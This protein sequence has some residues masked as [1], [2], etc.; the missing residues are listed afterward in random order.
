MIEI[1]AV[2]IE[3][4]INNFTLDKELKLLDYYG[5]GKHRDYHFKEDLHRSVLGEMMVRTLLCNKS[6]LK[7]S[8]LSF[9]KNKFG[10]P[11]IRGNNNL[12]FNVSHSKSW[13]CVAISDKEI[14]IDIEEIKKRI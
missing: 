13:V 2:N 1:Y 6:N 10:K 5:E 12:F 3:K 11:Y 7:N 9:Y 4:S 14:G 8:Q